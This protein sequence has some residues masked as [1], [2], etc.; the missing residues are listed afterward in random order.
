MKPKLRCASSLAFSLR[1]LSMLTCSPSV[2]DLLAH[3]ATCPRHWARLDA[4]SPGTTRRDAS[5]GCCAQGLIFTGCSAR[6]V[7]ET[8][9]IQQARH[10]R[11]RLKGATLLIRAQGST[12][13]VLFA[14]FSTTTFPWS[15]LVS[16]NQ[17]KDADSSARYLARK[18]LSLLSIGQGVS[19]R[20]GQ[21]S[22]AQLTN[23]SSRTL[24]QVM[25]K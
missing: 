23:L 16:E 17:R 4:K 21:L 11:R 18:R 24:G 15:R 25:Q 2:R 20:A 14:L 7:P 8:L 10:R 9:R 6:A 5:S 1:S 22:Q 3:W 12:R 13:Q 19:R